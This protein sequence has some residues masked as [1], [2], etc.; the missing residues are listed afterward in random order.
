MEK[1]M[2]P[3][4]VV[5]LALFAASAVVAAEFAQNAATTRKTEVVQALHAPDEA[6]RKKDR[7]EMERLEADQPLCVE[8]PASGSSAAICGPGT[9]LRQSVSLIR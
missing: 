5:V 6:A 1:R 2:T 7:A 8:R 9:D 3:T 4:R